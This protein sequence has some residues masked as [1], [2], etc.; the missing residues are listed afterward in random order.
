M[1]DSTLSS[2]AAS[3]PGGS[4]GSG[5][6][7][8]RI[9]H[10]YDLLNRVLSL[11]G[12]SRWRRLTVAA[13]HLPP[14][15]RVL[16][17]ATGTADL[18]LEIVRRHPDASV[19]GTDPSTRM[20]EIARDKAREAGLSERVQLE[21]GVAE[22]LPFE[23]DS[24]DGV[25]IAFGI[26]NVPDRASALREMARVT[27]SSGR[28]AILELGEPH[29]GVLAPLARLH[30][31]HVVPRIGALLSGEREY[32]YLQESIEAFPAP[33]DFVELMESS[34]LVVR[35][36]TPLSFGACNLFVGQPLPTARETS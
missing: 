32:R 33:A 4:L 12:D 22:Q 24:F 20:L 16:D 23:G 35:D 36:V 17:L 13:L 15:A 21:E 26:R 34:G 14:E 19:V 7:F 10:R 9:A 25:C 11:G 2:E 18:A 3:M 29:S 27:K 28:V 5:E 1:E 31:R 8:D 6:M 30:V